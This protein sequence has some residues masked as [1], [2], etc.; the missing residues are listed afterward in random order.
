MLPFADIVVGEYGS[1]VTE[2][3]WGLPREVAEAL[4]AL[5]GRG[6]LSGI[7]A[8]RSRLRAGAGISSRRLPAPDRSIGL[9]L[10]WVRK[11][12]ARR[13]VVTVKFRGGEEYPKLDRLKSELAPLCAEF[14]LAR[15][16]ANKNE[17]CVM[18][19]CQMPGSSS[20]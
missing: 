18:G 2:G 20:E 7:L 13:F 12:W 1:S 17:A 11:G 9:A 16:C 14:R 6:C 5:A 3:S 10:D 15:L 4:A 19:S 8:K